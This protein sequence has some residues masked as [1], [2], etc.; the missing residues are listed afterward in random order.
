MH[1]RICPPIY[2]ER[3]GHAAAKDREYIE[4]CYDLVVTTMQ[5][6]LDKIA[7]TADISPFA[8]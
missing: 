7:K 1:T 8:R 4:T 3:Y 6:E 2:F 5:T